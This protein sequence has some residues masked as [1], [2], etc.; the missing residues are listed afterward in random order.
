MKKSLSIDEDYDFSLFG[1]SCHAKDYRLSWEINGTLGLD[2]EKTELESGMLDDE[3]PLNVS[4]YFD[5]ESHLQ[6][7]LITN[8]HIGGLWF[9]E[10]PN[11]DYF[12]R[13]SGP[14]HEREMDSCKNMLQR[15]E[16]ILAIVQINPMD[17]K[18]RIN[19]MF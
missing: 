13:I 1:I 15:I 17:L 5:E 18:S 16:S 2:L 19:L 12:L 4:S 7:T 11:L 10:M 8:K 9:P 14:M 3:I 6:Y